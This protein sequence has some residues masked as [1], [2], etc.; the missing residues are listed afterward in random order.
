VQSG[1]AFEF[2]VNR[3][4]AQ[5]LLNDMG[6]SD[7]H[8]PASLDNAPIAVDIPTALTAGYGP[9][10]T[11]S[12]DGFNTEGSGSAGRQFKD[13]V[14]F[15]QMPSPTVNTPPDLDVA[16]LAQMA[17]RLTG[18]TEAEAAAYSNTVDW[19]STLVIPIPRNGATYTQVAVDGVMGNLIVRP[20]DDAPQFA[21]VWVKDGRLYAIG[22]LGVDTANALDMANSLH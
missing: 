12:A 18:M 1:T 19:A 5:A 8:L 16:R 15:V 20:V 6:Y 2:L 17:L 3:E 10:P 14:L 21:L 11:P 22:G 7:L 9:C 4:R 13:C